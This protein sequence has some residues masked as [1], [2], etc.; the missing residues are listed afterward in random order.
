MSGPS[1]PVPPGQDPSGLNF[2]DIERLIGGEIGTFDLPCPV[3]G[4]RRAGSAS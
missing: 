1:K 4:P 2:A 3:C